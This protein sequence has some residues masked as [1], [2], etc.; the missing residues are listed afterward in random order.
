MLTRHRNHEEAHCAVPAPPALVFEH[1]DR[2][3]RLSAHMSRPSWRLAGTSMSIEPDA[4]GG[5]AVGSHIRLRGRVLGITLDVECVVIDHTVPKF[6]EWQTLGTPRLLV[7]GPYRMSVRI[8]QHNGG[9]AVAISID[10]SPPSTGWQRLLSRV[11]G[12]VYARWCVNQMVRDIEARF[13]AS[14]QR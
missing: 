10:W 6:K 4:A 13:A 11:V 7:I 3:E 14:G 1:V 12:G 2:P 5:R 8:Q 9:S